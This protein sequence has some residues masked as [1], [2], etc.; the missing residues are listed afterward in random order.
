[1]TLEELSETEQTVLLALV[2]LTARLDGNVSE[3][4]IAWIERISEQ[5]GQARFEA[6]RD[7]AANFADPDAILEAARGVTRPEARQVIYELVYDIASSDT[8]AERESDLLARLSTLWDLP[9]RSGDA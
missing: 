5:L 7:A 2:G 3:I 9:Q 4:E 1:M 6:I 8:V